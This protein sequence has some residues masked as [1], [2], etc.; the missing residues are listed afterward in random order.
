VSESD[1]CQGC[2]ELAT[3]LQL[4]TVARYLGLAVAARELVDA[5]SLE[6]VEGSVPLDALQP[7]RPLPSDGSDSIRRL[8]ACTAC[9]R[10]F[11]L[12]A[13]TYHGGA[14]WGTDPL[15]SA[16]PHRPGPSG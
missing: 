13:D 10:R 15:G 5:G 7:G 9:G 6:L 3:R 11:I 2:D 14:A 16:L 4:P 1:T 12:W 8:F